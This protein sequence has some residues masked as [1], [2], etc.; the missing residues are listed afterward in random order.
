[1]LFVFSLTLSLKASQ[2]VFLIHHT[3]SLFLTIALVDSFN[4]TGKWSD[5]I[6]PSFD[7]EIQKRSSV[8]E[9]YVRFPVLVDEC[10]EVRPHVRD[11]V[12]SH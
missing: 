7:G 8:R 4:I 12:L 3:S 11:L 6:R 9:Y 1:M 2:F 10:P 5:V